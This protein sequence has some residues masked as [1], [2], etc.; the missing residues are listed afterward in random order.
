LKGGDPFVF[1]RGGEEVLACLA[2]GI[3]VTVV[4]GISS[5]LAAPAAAG[6][7]LTHRGMAADFT[8]VSGHLDPGRPLGSGIDWQALATGPATLVLL[9][10]M[11]HLADITAELIARGR[12]ASTPAA[13][14][15]QATLAGQQVVRASLGELADAVRAAGLGAPAVVVIGDVVE[16]LPPY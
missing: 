5:A 9:M 2:A 11:E 16:A 7:P 6:I 13:A 1:G 8:V 3:S 15:H 10:A 4:P 14:V 12:A